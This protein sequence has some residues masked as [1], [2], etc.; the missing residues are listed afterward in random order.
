MTH[1]CCLLVHTSCGDIP[2]RLHIGNRFRIWQMVRRASAHNSKGTSAVSRMG[3]PMSKSP[4]YP[5]HNVVT[6]LCST[7]C[8]LM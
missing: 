8:D 4:I 5:F 2:L 3:H 1:D 7:A 6:E